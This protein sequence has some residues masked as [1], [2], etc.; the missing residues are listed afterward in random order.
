MEGIE[1][2][3][4]RYGMDRNAVG[5]LPSGYIASQGTATDVGT[6]EAA[7]RRVGQVQVAL[8]AASPD[9]AASAQASAVTPTLLGVTPA[10]P[11]D[12]RYRTVYQGTIALR[13]RL[14]G[15]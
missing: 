6:T 3:Q 9:R 5:T 10:L 8:L 1:N 14:Y 15:N 12:G 4:F 2:M 7:W 11:A 13:N